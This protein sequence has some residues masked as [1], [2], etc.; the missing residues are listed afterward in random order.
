ME[1]EEEEE[2]PLKF[3]EIEKVETSQQET[4]NPAE[5]EKLE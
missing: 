5:K 2:K 3:D 4:E 1:Q